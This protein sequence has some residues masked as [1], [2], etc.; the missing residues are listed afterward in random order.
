ML[1][2]PP[3]FSYRSLGWANEALAGDYPTPA[4]HDGMGIVA[5][6]ADTWDAVLRVLLPGAHLAAFA[7]SR[8]YHRIASAIDDA[9]FEIRDMLLWMYGSGFPKSLDVAKAIDKAG[10]TQRKSG[11]AA[12]RRSKGE[13]AS[14]IRAR[15]EGRCRLR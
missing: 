6:T 9:G 4:A 12:D 3:G 7:G 14:R 5:S 15:A 11:E 8:T 1:R 2:L 13:D 10:G